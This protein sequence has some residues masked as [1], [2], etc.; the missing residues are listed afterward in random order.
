M[1]KD[2]S[3]GKKIKVPTFGFNF[4]SKRI[5]EQLRRALADL[6]Y[7]D[8][9][10]SVDGTYRILSVGSANWPLIDGGPCVN[11][12]SGTG[13]GS[14]YSTTV[15]NSL[16]Q[17][18][19]VECTESYR[20][21]FGT[22]KAIPMTFFSAAAPFEPRVIGSDRAKAIVKAAID[23]FPNTHCVLCWPHVYLYLTG[24]RF[25][26]YMS[27]TCTKETR[28]GIEA[29]IELLHQARNQLMF[30]ELFACMAEVWRGEDEGEFAEYFEKNYATGVWSRWFYSAAL[31]PGVP[32][33]QNA[34]EAHH[35][36]IKKVLG[37]DL[38][39]A[40]PLIM[41]TV[42]AP[43]ILAAEGTSNGEIHKW[44]ATVR[45]APRLSATIAAR[46]R[47]L[48]KTIQCMRAAEPLQEGWP[49]DSDGTPAILVAYS[50]TYAN[51]FVTIDRERA[52]HYK[53]LSRGSNPFNRGRMTRKKLKKL[54]EAATGLHVV[55]VFKA[56]FEDQSSFL[57][58][59]G[60]VGLPASEGGG[61]A[62]ENYFRLTCDCEENNRSGGQ[63][64]SHVLAVAAGKLKG[65]QHIN[66]DLLLE[67]AAP[68]RRGPGRP[69]LVPAGNCRGDG[70]GASSSS[71]SS[72]SSSPAK[73]SPA[74]FLWML[75]NKGPI[76]Y[77]KWRVAKEFSQVLRVGTIVGYRKDF[78]EEPRPHTESTP[79]TVLWS[80]HYEPDPSDV[81]E[82][83][84]ARELAPLMARASREGCWG[85]HARDSVDAQLQVVPAA[86]RAASAAEAVAPAAHGWAPGAAAMAPAALGGAPRPRPRAAAGSRGS[87]GPHRPGITRRDPNAPPPWGWGGTYAPAPAEAREESRAGL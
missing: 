75:Q 18:C 23:V 31:M 36:Q 5:L 83:Y 63:I 33:N 86:A 68:Q 87:Q 48:L 60:G 78:H 16:F 57:K 22:L 71:S 77:H 8:V 52:S 45:V 2:P 51:R 6:G 42:S 27:S 25:F 3:T 19:R 76:Y 13:G 69:R 67:A 41:A 21:Y 44:P 72:S 11:Y 80:V 54:I 15:I 32:A 79:H 74:H 59:P 66:L 53:M 20:H 43:L 39:K 70:E 29:D 73:N 61:A 4:S 37:K 35:N 26:K 50:N 17:F 64:C 38:L 55:V 47:E 30:D 1:I 62:G 46:A 56:S 9:A 34:V 14:E 82:E 58:K 65:P 10:Y 81:F 84:T 7:D 24:G 49:L 40:P 12:Y 28:E 85:P